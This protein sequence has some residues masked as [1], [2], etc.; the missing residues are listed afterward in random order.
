MNPALFVAN[1]IIEFC[2]DNDMEI[3][4]LKLQKVL[5]YVNARSLVEL[6]TP[7][8]SDK[9]Q[10]WQYGPVIPKVY[11]EFKEYGAFPL[12]RDA[13]SQQI[14]TLD[15]SS[16]TFA[17]T[18]QEYDSGDIEHTD[19]ID[20]TIRH[21][22]SYDSFRLV[23]LTHE[24]EIW[25]KDEYKIKNGTRNIS[26]TDEEIREYFIEHEKARVWERAV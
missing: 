26:Y 2:A 25:K 14:V 13:I 7:I 12:T 11:H 1:Y 22:D 20:D 10:K 19:I 4:N 8:F 24:H 21:L 17:V 16:D 9:I 15:T 5:Y 6:G 18:V 23:E 3:S